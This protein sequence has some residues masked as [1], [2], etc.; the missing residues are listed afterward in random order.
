MFDGFRPGFL[1]VAGNECRSWLWEVSSCLS[2]DLDIAFYSVPTDGANC[3]SSFWMDRWTP[4]SCCI[5]WFL[6]DRMDPEMQIRVPSI[7]GL[8]LSDDFVSLRTLDECLI[9]QALCF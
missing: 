1:G 7:D 4:C 5:V 6:S 8:S 3:Y 9:T 2:A